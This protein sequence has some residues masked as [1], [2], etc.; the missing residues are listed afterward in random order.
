MLALDAELEVSGMACI[1]HGGVS[2]ELLL[3]ATCKAPIF[4]YG[5][6]AATDARENGMWLLIM[7]VVLKR[8]CP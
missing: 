1:A 7:W 6:A 4:T 8:A 3:P 5:D 2:A